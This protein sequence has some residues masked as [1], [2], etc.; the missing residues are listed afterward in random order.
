MLKHLI[1]IYVDESFVA[2]KN[3]SGLK[4]GNFDDFEEIKIIQKFKKFSKCSLISFQIN[5]NCT[6]IVCLKMM[7]SKY[8]LKIYFS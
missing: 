2:L 3:F 1:F 4:N 7:Q 5:F 6:T 8:Y